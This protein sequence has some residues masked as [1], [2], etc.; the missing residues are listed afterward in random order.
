[1]GIGSNNFLIDIPEIP[2]N[3]NFWM[4]RTNNGLFFN[5]F[6][7][8]HYISIG[9]NAIKKNT[10]PLSKP[11]KE[12]ME[13]YI[14]YKYK[15]SVPGLAINK[16]EK[17]CF[18]LKKGDIAVITGKEEIAFA[19]IGDYYEENSERF[20]EQLEIDTNDKI[21]KGLRQNIIEC[22]Y[23]KRRKI[24]IISIISNREEINPYLYKALL[25]NKHS[26]SSLNQYS[27][28]ILSS[29]YDIYLWKGTLSFSFKVQTRDNINA[30][31]L[32][33]FICSFTSLLKN[34]DEKDISVKIALHSPGDIILQVGNWFSNSSNYLWIF[35]ILMALFGGKMGGVEFPSIW[36]VIKYFIDRYDNQTTKQLNEE[37]L[38]LENEK[39]Q[40]E[41]NLL[42][43]DDDKHKQINKDTQCLSQASA[44]LDIKPIS[45]QIINI[46]AIISEMENNN[47]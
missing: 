9:W 41:I 10:F 39:L 29:C 5:E 27:D 32:S 44:T 30:V 40:E 24:D 16:C 34:I 37:K 47:K 38:R 18:N 6:I 21:S 17:F 2:T 1:M 25:L 31:V 36:N 43:T 14:K 19:I 12:S 4:I 46:D 22:P 23:C 45:D 26:L 11:Q 13:N 15:T 42:K 28:T 8:K 7:T 20:T 33:N 3:C 35:V